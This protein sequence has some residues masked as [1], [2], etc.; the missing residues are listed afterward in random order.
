[1][2]VYS[3]IKSE[4]SEARVIYPPK[5][6]PCTLHIFLLEVCGSIYLDPPIPCGT[7]GNMFR[8]I[9]HSVSC[10]CLCFVPACDCDPSFV[11]VITQG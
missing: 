6:H 9:M 10:E 2:N 8:H 3:A 4:D 11:Y 7:M 5:T 1:M